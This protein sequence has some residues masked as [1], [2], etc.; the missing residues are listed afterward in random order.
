MS[1]MSRLLNIMKM[2]EEHPELE[3]VTKYG[4]RMSWEQDSDESI[5]INGLYDLKNFSKHESDTVKYVV[6]YVKYH[7]PEEHQAMGLANEGYGI[8]YKPRYIIHEIIIQKYQ[9]S[10]SPYDRFPVGLAYATK[11]G[12]F[13]RNALQYFENCMDTITPEFMDKFISYTPLC[14][15]GIIS[16]L[17]EHEHEY[18]NAIYYTELQKEYGDPDNPYFDTRISELEQKQKN[19]KPK[20][21]LR[22]SERQVTFEKD[23]VS[24]TKMFLESSILPTRKS[25][26]KEMPKYDLERFMVACN[27][28]MAH[29]DEM[30][31]Y[32][33]SDEEERENVNDN[34]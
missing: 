2:K 26:S 19:W 13:V 31:R 20:R 18:K 9:D 12:Y 10:Q 16:K 5:T 3:Q 25:L 6:N 15:Y 14:T 17:Y 24:A 23:V 11:G 27:A 29:D 30:E 21:N 7:Y 4:G 1:I 33:I 34:V 8:K 32:N 22:M 28:Q